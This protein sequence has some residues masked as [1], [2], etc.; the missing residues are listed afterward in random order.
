MGK[1][2]TRLA[3]D[4]PRALASLKLVRSTGSARSHSV[5]L[6]ELSKMPFTLSLSK[7]PL[8]YLQP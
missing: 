1:L 8:A 6:G 5:S 7:G 4:F 2:D 3:L